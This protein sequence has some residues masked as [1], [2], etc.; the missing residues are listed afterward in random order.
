[1]SKIIVCN[2]CLDP[3]EYCPKTRCDQCGGKLNGYPVVRDRIAYGSA[4]AQIEHNKKVEN[5][6]NKG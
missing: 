5:E 4:K 6:R 1:M 2:G 3:G